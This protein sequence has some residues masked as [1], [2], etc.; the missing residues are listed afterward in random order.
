[1]ARPARSVGR[2]GAWVALCLGLGMHAAVTAQATTATQAGL[3]VGGLWRIVQARTEPMLDMRLASLEFGA[4]GRLAGH[5]SCNPL[6]ARYSL[7]GERLKISALA[8]TA[9]TCARLQL[10]QEDRI[11]SALEAA[12]TARVRPDGLLELR[13]AEGRGVLRARRFDALE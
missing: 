8:T 9:L 13:D 1:M 5:T 4:D 11:L 2:S 3:S 12:A 6:T 7:F 10:E